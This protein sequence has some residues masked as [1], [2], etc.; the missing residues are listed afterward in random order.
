MCYSI[1]STETLLILK[2]QHI[3]TQIKQYLTNKHGILRSCNYKGGH[4]KMTNF[5]KIG[6]IFALQLA[7]P[8]IIESSGHQRSLTQHPYELLWQFHHQY[9]VTFLMF[10][11]ADVI[12]WDLFLQCKQSNSFSLSW[13]LHVA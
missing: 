5:I 1:S 8:V 12:W 7:Y 3:T 10:Q 11:A 13:Y 6:I 4:I 2:Y 9:M